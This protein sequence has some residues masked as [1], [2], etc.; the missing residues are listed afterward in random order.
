MF[1][2]RALSAET[3]CFS[4]P[5]AKHVLFCRALSTDSVALLIN[6]HTLMSETAQWCLKLNISCAETAHK[7]VLFDASNQNAEMER[8]Y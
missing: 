6:W 4:K 7:S 1:T 3:L 2:E 5:Q 8:L